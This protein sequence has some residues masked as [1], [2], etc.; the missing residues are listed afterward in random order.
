MALSPV[1]RLTAPLRL[2]L[3]QLAADGYPHE[4]CGL[5]V[6][7]TVDRTTVVERITSARNLVADRPHDRFRLDDGDFLAADDAARRAGLDIVGI[8]H[9]HPDHPA[10]PSVTD[11]E[12]AWPAYS[13]LILGVG[14]HGV[15]ESRSWLLDGDRFV[16]QSIKEIES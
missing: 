7:R 9:T 10:R 2:E 11:L 5:L 3:D 1:L 12:A 13:Y 8:W 15:E 16:E 6:G 14:A 4:V